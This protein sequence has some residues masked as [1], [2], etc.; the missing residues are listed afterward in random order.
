MTFFDY[1]SGDANA[2]A[3]Q[4]TFLPNA[5]ENDWADLLRMSTV[6]RLATGETLITPGATDRSLF[7]V[8]EGQVELLAPSGRKWRHLTTVGAGGV[9]GELAFFDGVQRAALARA[10]SD[11]SVAELTR[12]S[13]AALGRTRPELAMSVAMDVGRILAQ[14]YRQL[15]GL[16]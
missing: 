16:T 12:E 4:Q 6:R 5:S 2:A 1:P 11:V 13:F 9:V 8:L 15:Q 3:A 10:I 14:R 7:I